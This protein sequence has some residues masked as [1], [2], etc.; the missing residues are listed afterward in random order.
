MN[1]YQSIWTGLW[2]PKQW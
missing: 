1:S 2:H